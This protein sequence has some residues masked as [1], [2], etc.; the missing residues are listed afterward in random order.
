MNHTHN[1][2]HNHT[3]LTISMRPRKQGLCISESE[4]LQVLIRIQ[5]NDKNYKPKMPV[6][7]ALVLDHSGSM[8][9]DRLEVA[10]R[11]CHEFVSRLSDDDEFSLV[12]YDTTVKTL[13]ELTPVAHIRHSLNAI[14]SN[15]KPGGNTNLHQGWLT[16][17]E[18][19]AK[20]AERSR[21]CRVVLVS[22]GMA[23]CGIVQNEVI[24]E[25]VKKLAFAGVTTSTVGIGLGFNEELMTAIAQAGMGNAMYGDRIVDIQESFDYEISLI[26]HLAWTQVSLEIVYSKLEWTIH[27]EYQEEEGGI[28]LTWRIPDIAA[29]SE[30][31]MLVSTSMESVI[32][33]YINQP[34][35]PILQVIVRATNAEGK[36]QQFHAELEQIPIFSLDD[37]EFLL[38]NTQVM[39]RAQEIHASN[40]QRQAFQ[41]LNRG[42]WGA[43]EFYLA[44]MERESKEING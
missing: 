17:A 36:Q 26:K 32:R 40:L 42:E 22:D 23:N 8:S 9:G 41:A 24:C 31:W 5:A 44:Q 7:V 11:A 27:N 30:A 33:Q 3:P 4:E 6:S 20:R 1:H 10:K 18:I 35:L 28:G 21:V 34:E 13:I 2:N 37:Y 15:I 12:I 43:V 19:L 25:Q 39:L 38:E 29:D 14:L 16:G